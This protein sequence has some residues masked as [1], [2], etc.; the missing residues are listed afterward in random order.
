MER[1]PESEGLTMFLELKS[2]ST[3]RKIVDGSLQSEGTFSIANE[4]TIFGQD[5]LPVIRFEHETMPMAIMTLNQTTLLLWENCTDCF[6][7]EY[8]RNNFLD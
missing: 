5:P 7:H 2:D 8:S 3:Y 6:G 4:P 1:T